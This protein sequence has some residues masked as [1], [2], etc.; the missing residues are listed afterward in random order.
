M[1][2]LRG[3]DVRWPESDG[4]PWPG[5]TAGSGWE[6]RCSPPRAARSRQPTSSWGSRTP[7]MRA[8][9]HHHDCN[10][11]II[12]IITLTRSTYWL[13]TWL[14]SRPRSPRSRRTR[15][16][17]NI[18]SNNDGVTKLSPSPSPDY[19]LSV[20]HLLWAL[21]D[22]LHNLL[23]LVETLAADQWGGHSCHHNYNYHSIITSRGGCPGPCPRRAWGRTCAWSWWSRTPGCP[24]PPPP[25]A[26]PGHTGHHHHYHHLGLH[27]DHDDL[28]HHAA[29]GLEVVHGDL[30]RLARDDLL[31][32][33]SKKPQW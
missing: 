13:S 7:R 4:V 33:V 31:N 10:I 23:W 15:L 12:I 22:T 27:L 9:H 2:W 20:T 3:N 6:P 19:R 30:H 8:G 17:T 32:R 16:Q 11:I 24:P 25:R 18:I 14:R 5:C 29:V 1:Y 21:A 28:A 26:R